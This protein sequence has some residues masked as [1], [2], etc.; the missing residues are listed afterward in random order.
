MAKKLTSESANREHNVA[1]IKKL[2]ADCAREMNG[3]DDERKELNERAGD[4]REK[5]RDSG[6]QVAAFNFSRKLDKMEA[7]ARDEYLDSLRINMESMGIGGQGTLFID[8]AQPQSNGAEAAG[9]TA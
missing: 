8:E 4:I 3:I 7:E 5:L 2:I 9:A 6:V 1:D